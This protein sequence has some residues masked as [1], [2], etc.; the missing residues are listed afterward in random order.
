MRTTLLLL[1]GTVLLGLSAG[2]GREKVEMPENPTPPPKEA[3]GSMETGEPVES[4]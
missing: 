3:P 4:P 1:L 2:C